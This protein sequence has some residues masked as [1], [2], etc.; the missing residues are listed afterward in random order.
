MIILVR[1]L[2]FLLGF[3]YLGKSTTFN[4]VFSM[5]IL[6]MYLSYLL[7]IV[8]MLLFGRKPGAHEPGQFKLGRAGMFIN[9]AAIAWLVLSIFFRSILEPPILLLLDHPIDCCSTWPKISPVTSV[10]INYSTVVLIGLVTFGTIYSAFK[11]R[12]KNAGSVI[13]L[14]A[15]AGVTTT[16]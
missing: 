6:D 5:A 3:I 1:I 2:R 16:S 8:Y 9:I 10:N 7:P 14:G 12:R 13:E 11:G 4:A 15:V